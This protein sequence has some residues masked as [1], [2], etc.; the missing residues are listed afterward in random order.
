MCDTLGS[1]GG[2]GVLFGKNSDR[3]PNEPQVLEFVP[4]KKHSEAELKATYISVPQVSETHAVLLSRPTWMWGAEIGV[5]DCGVCI[6][7]EAVFTL[8]KYGKSG[9]TGMDML[10]LA[11]ERSES[12]KDALNTITELLQTY[13]Q[14]GNCGYDHDFFYD[15]SFLIMDAGSLLVLETCGKEWVYKSYDRAS[16]SNRLSIGADGDEYSSGKAYDFC[17]RHT[18]RIYTAGSGSAARRRQTQGC[19]AGVE[20]AADIMSALRTHG[21]KAVNPFAKGSVASACMHFGGVVGDHTTASLVADLKADKTIVWATGSSTP[22]VSLF[23]P[24]LFG[25][26]PTA[27]VFSENDVNAKKYW[28]EQERFRRGLI[29]KAVPQEFFAERDSIESQWIKRADEASGADFEAL[30]AEC[31]AEEKSFYDKWSAYSFEEVKTSAGFRN[32]WA[33]KTEVLISEAAQLD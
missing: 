4:A 30:S 3:S 2:R 11:L 5:N 13:G 15:N 9:L 23:K 25:A 10:R 17:R 20:S 32:R 19:V 14:G 22:C 33:Q 29:G 21:P 8:G 16:I 26:K 6:G 31:A 7:N 28:Y 18:E 1:I 27:P 12:A 24:W